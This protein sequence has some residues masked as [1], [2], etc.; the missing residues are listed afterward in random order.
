MF[1]VFYDYKYININRCCGYKYIDCLYVYK[2]NR[3]FVELVFKYKWMVV[4]Y[5]LLGW[6][7]WINSVFLIIFKEIIY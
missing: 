1:W 6:C 5:M 7:D 3:L 4:K 2:C